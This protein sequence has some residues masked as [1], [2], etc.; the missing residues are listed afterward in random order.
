MMPESPAVQDYYPESF[1]HCFG[2]GRLNAQGHQIKTHVDGDEMVA[3]FT[4]EPY[5]TF[6]LQYSPKIQQLPC[7]HAA[8]PG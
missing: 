5:H 7:G 6:L 4:P 2:C 1:A 3:L 8:Q